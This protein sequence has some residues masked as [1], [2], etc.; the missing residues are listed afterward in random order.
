MNRMLWI[1]LWFFLG[2]YVLGSTGPLIVLI[3]N[4]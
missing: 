1:L 2:L 3:L 4:S